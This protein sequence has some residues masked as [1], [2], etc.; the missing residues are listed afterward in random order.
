MSYHD[1]QPSGDPQASGKLADRATAVAAALA[2]LGLR[3]QERVLIMLTD[4]PVFL[5]A[6]AGTIRRGAVPLPVNPHLPAADIAAIVTHTGARLVLTSAE[7]V[8]GLA[9]LDAEPP[10]RVDGHQELWV[11]ALRKH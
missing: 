9:D 3:P 4:G 10:V 6:F 8:D 1:P 11:S 2:Q 7:R 5:D